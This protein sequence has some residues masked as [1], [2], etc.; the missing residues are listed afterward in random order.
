MM[1]KASRTALD[2]D[3]AADMREKIYEILRNDQIC[4]RLDPATQN[5]YKEKLAKLQAQKTDPLFDFI[6]Q[7]FNIKLN[8]CYHIG[9]QSVDSSVKNIV[10]VLANFDPFVLNSV[11]EVAQLS[12]SS[13][14]ALALMY[15][16]GQ[17]PNLGYLEL[18]E[19]VNIARIDELY[20]QQHNGLVEGAH[21]W[22]Q[23]NT[24]TT[25]A[26]ARSIIGLAKLRYF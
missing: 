2:K 20:Q 11:Y 12:K 8:V 10:S 18:P 25:F 22:D 1:A 23:I 24:L 17:D 15:Q 21:D 6:K 9:Q 16:D 13:A 14:L 7:K 4:Y 19:A 5:E 3:L 26:A